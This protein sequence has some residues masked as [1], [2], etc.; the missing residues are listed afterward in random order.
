MSPLSGL[1]AKLCLALFNP[2]GEKTCSTPL[3]TKAGRVFPQAPQTLLQSLTPHKVLDEQPVRVNI[4]CN[5]EG[6]K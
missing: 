1:H 5:K 4:S 6:Q 3:K 2:G